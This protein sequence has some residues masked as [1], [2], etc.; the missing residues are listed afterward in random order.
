MFAP[1]QLFL[2]HAYCEQGREADGRAIYDPLAASHFTTA[3]FDL[4]WMVAMSVC[5]DVALHLGDVA[6]ADVL[7]ELLSPYADQVLAT[8]GVPC[9]A[10][11]H[12][13]GRLAAALGRFDGAETHFAAAETTQARIGAPTWLARTRLEWARMLLA[14]RQPGD[15]DRA[16]NSSARPWVPPGTEPP[17]RRAASSRV[18]PSSP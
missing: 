12:Y 15:A 1:L 10:G 13:L 17:Q 14:R 3:G 2:A 7:Y 6:A 16:R 18:L 4:T 11:S 5:T 9:G 8:A